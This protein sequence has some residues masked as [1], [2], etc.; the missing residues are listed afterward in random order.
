M[1]G[2]KDLP[3][4]TFYGNECFYTKFHNQTH[5]SECQ[6]LPACNEVVYKYYIDRQRKFT[7]EEISDFCPWDFEPHIQYIDHFEAPNFNIS[8]LKNP[9][10]TDNLRYEEQL[11]DHNIDV[12]KH[13]ISTQFARIHIRLDGTTHLRR[14]QSLKY[15]SGDKIAIIGGTFGLFTGF[16][17]IALFEALYWILVTVFKLVWLKRNPILLEKNEEDPM[18]QEMKNL[19]KELLE[20]K[21]NEKEASAKQES[22]IKNLNER[23]SALESNPTK[24][25]SQEMIV[26]DVELDIAQ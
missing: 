19:R 26:E 24:E 5:K 10:V 16:S 7:S 17:F 2:K 14:L 1:A 22:I 9:T 20:I 3:I 4:C 21:Q 15:T 12:C 23:L 25:T 8:R 11:R 6:C 13:Y 18:V